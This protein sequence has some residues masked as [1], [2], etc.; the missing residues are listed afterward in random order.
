MLLFNVS[1]LSIITH[2]IYYIYKRGLHGNHYYP[3]YVAFPSYATYQSL[4]ESIFQGPTY[5]PNTHEPFNQ[6][7]SKI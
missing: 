1:V 5:V 7:P 4:L 3:T 2:I 6:Y